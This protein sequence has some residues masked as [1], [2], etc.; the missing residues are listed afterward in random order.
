M[1][2]DSIDLLKIMPRLG[3]AI[4]LIDANEKVTPDYVLSGMPEL[5]GIERKL[6]TEVSAVR[7]AGG[8]VLLRILA[9]NEKRDDFCRS[10]AKK[11]IID[12]HCYM[13]LDCP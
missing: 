7:T 5:T 12:W 2:S 13:V 6:Y 8:E 1:A 4:N 3:S 9:P 10:D 11:C